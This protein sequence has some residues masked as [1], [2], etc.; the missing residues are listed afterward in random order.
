MKSRFLTGNIAT[1]NLDFFDSAF[2]FS[3]ESIHVNCCARDTTLTN[4]TCGQ[5]IS[6][7]GQC[8]AIEGSLCPSGN[9]TGD[10]KDCRPNLGFEEGGDPVKRKSYSVAALPS[11]AFKW[12]TPRC[13]VRYHSACCFHPTCRSQRRQLC[14]WMNYF[15]GGFIDFSWSLSRRQYFRQLLSSTRQHSPW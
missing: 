3:N 11:W 1:L 10:P 15:T 14:S 4:V 5:G 7:I 2:T 6:C 8:A 13:R 9:C 12:C